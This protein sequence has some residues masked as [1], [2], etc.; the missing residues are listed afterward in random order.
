[1]KR[2][3]GMPLL[4]L[5]EV[6]DQTS[7]L[8][9]AEA[10]E[11]LNRFAAI[12]VRSRHSDGAVIYHG[13]LQALSATAADIPEDLPL[14]RARLR[15]P[16][17]SALPFRLAL[18]RATHSLPLE[19]AADFWQ[20]DLFLSDFTLL[21]DDLVA[22]DLIPATGTMPRHLVPKADNDTPV[23]LT[24]AAGLR[25]ERRGADADVVARLIDPMTNGAPFLPDMPSGAVVHVTCT[26]PHFLIGRSQIGMTLRDMLFDTSETYSP[27]MVTA[28]GQSNAWRGFAMR[29][30]TIYTRGAALGR[31]G[32]SATL[33]DFLIGDPA[34]LQAEIELQFG[35]SP[36]D[37]ATFVFKQG[38]DETPLGFDFDQ[39]TLEITARPGEQVAL[40]ASL[41]MSE[42]PSDAPEG[43][44]G[45]LAE[46]KFPNS[47][48]EI[49]EDATGM[50]AHGDILRIT[51]IE[52]IV[53]DG[54]E[55]QLRK[56]EFTVRM[57]AS[58]TAPRLSVTVA[59]TTL[60]NAVDLTGPVSGLQGMALSA[61]PTPAQSSAAFDWSCPTLGIED[62]G[63]IFELALPEDA[64]GEHILVLT[65]RDTDHAA[66]RLRIKLF[67]D[68]EA[69]V[70]IGCEDGVFDAESPT[71]PR[72]L[73]E[74]LGTYDLTAFHD[75]GGLHAG[76]D[77]AQIIAGGVLVPAGHIAQV[78]L[79]DGGTEVPAVYDR[80]V[81][82]L[83]PFGKDTINAWGEMFPRKDA[84]N[85]YH[86]ALLKWASNYPGAEF[87][88]IGRCD[89]VGSDDFNQ[90]LAEARAERVRAMLTTATG[91]QEA[92]EAG[93]VT[94]LGEQTAGTRPPELSEI[95]THDEE[96]QVGRLIVL[97]GKADDWPKNATGE[98]GVRGDPLDPGREGI[99]T[100]FRRADVFALGGDPLEGAQRSASSITDPDTRRALV[101]SAG[102]AVAPSDNADARADYRVKMVFAWDRPRWSG[103]RDLVPNMAEIEYAWSPSENG[104]STSAEVITVRGKYVYDDL[105]GFT[106]LIL[107]LSSEG[108]DGLLQTE[109]SAL[110]AALSFAP[111]LIPGIDF[112]DNLEG[113][114]A[115]IG[116]LVTI[117]AVGQV[118]L[119]EGSKTTL[120]AVEGKT[121]TRTIADPLAAFKLQL[122]VDYTNEM[123]VSAPILGLRT[124]EAQPMKLRYKKVGLGYDHTAEGAF[125]NRIGVVYANDS[126][127]IEDSGTWQIEGPLGALLR[128]TEFRMGAG[129][130][131]IEPKLALT[132]NAGVVEVSEA[133]FR[134]TFTG[135]EEGGI[136][137]SLRGLSAKVN[138]PATVIGEGRLQIEDGGVIKAAIDVTII[139]MQIRASVALAV[140]SPP[141]IAPSVFVNLY[142]RI[143]FPGGIPLGT[144]PIAIHGFIGQTVINGRRD[145]AE[146]E[147]VVTREIGWW[148]KNPEDKYAPARG[149]YA[150]GLGVVL[151]TLPD[152]SFSLSVTGMVVVAFPDP[153]VILGVEIDLLTIPETTAKDQ[154][155]GNSASI[156]GLVVIDT[157]A[158]TIAASAQYTVPKVLELKLPFGAYFPY[159]GSG[160]SAYVRIG[161]DNVEGRSGQPVTLTILPDT[162]NQKAWCYL[163][164]EG[165]GINR[166]GGEDGWDFDGFAIGLGAGFGVEMK[167]GPI[168]LSASVRLL[169]GVGTTPLIIKGG[170]FVTGK[171][172][173]VVISLG[174][175]GDIVLT[176]IH[177][178]DGPPTLSLEGEFCGEVSM[179]FFSIKGC[180]SFDIGDPPAI[181]PPPPPAPV[182]SISL[183]GR[184]GEVTGEATKG[185]PAGAALYDFIE[186][187]GAVENQG[188]PPEDNHTVWP[189]TVPVLNFAHFIEDRLPS[190]GQ[191]KPEAQPAGA[192][193]FGS[194]R[195]KH[196]Y[197]LTGLRL[198]RE[199]GGGLVTDPE[200]TRLQSAW[201]LSPARAPDDSSGAN[202]TPSEA[203]VTHLQL[204]DWDPFHWARASADG[205]AGQ[206]GDPAEV[207]GR[208]CDP[209][210]D[211]QPFC[212]RGADAR[213]LSP[214][215]Q[216]L[217][218]SA[219]PEG[220]YPSRFAAKGSSVLPR[221][222]GALQGAELASLVNALGLSIRGGAIVT[223]PQINLGGRYV[224]SGLRLPALH[225]V[226]GGRAT[227]TTLPWQ[228]QLDRQ[229]TQGV[230]TLLV[231]DQNTRDPVQPDMPDPR[232]CYHFETARIGQIADHIVL[233]P[234][235]FIATDPAA[236]LQI[237]D[238][239]DLSQPLDPRP[240]QDGRADLQISY[241]GA[242]MVLD[243]PCHDLRLSYL[244]PGTGGLRFV[245]THLDGRESFESADG[246]ASVAITTRL[247][248]Q[249]GIVAV[250]FVLDTKTIQLYQ[251][252][253]A[254]SSKPA[255]RQCVSFTELH[256]GLS[257]AGKISFDGVIA[258][259]LGGAKGLQL[260]DRVDATLT[261]P[262]MRPDGV[263]EIVI[264]PDGL[265]LEFTRLRQCAR[266]E[267][268]LIASGGQ[269]TGTAFGADGQK[270][271]SGTLPATRNVPL[272]LTLVAKH[273]I[274]RVT[275]TGGNGEAALFRI[276]CSTGATAPAQGCIDLARL[277]KSLDGMRSGNHEGLRLSYL[278]GRP[279]ALAD[280]VQMGPVPRAGADGAL[281]LVVPR[282]GVQIALPRPCRH[283]ELHVM[284]FTPRE[285]MAIGYDDAGRVLARARS[286]GRTGQPQIMALRSARG[287]A[288]V[289]ITGG[290]GD[291]VLYRFCCHDGAGQPRITRRCVD[292]KT[293]PQ[294]RRP[295]ASLSRE[296]VEFRD[297]AGD[298]N[299]RIADIVT[300]DDTRIT[301]RRDGANELVFGRGALEILLP[302]PCSYMRLT[303][304]FPGTGRIEAEAFDSNGRRV[305]S[306]GGSAR[307]QTLTLTL[308]GPEMT[309][310][311][312]KNS[313][314]VAALDEIC[315]ELSSAP[316]P[317][318]PNRDRL[319]DAPARENES[320]LPKVT[321]PDTNGE[322]SNWQ[323]NVVQSFARTTSRPACRLV[324]YTMP[325]GL[326]HFERATVIPQSA[327][328]DITLIGLCGVDLK[329]QDWHDQ[330]AKLRDA[331]ILGFSGAPG[332]AVV[333]G[334]RPII[335]D[336]DTTYRIEIDWDYQSWVGQQDTDNA[337]AV[338]PESEWQPGETQIFRFRTASEGTLDEALQ[339]GPNEHIFNPRDLNRYLLEVEPENGAE[340]H[341]TDDP[342]VF[343]FA[344][345]HVPNLL[346]Q[347]QRALDVEIKR[348]DPP[349]MPD[350]SQLDSAR[351]P[352]EGDLNWFD[353]PQDL[354]IPRDQRLAKALAD[355]PCLPED[356][357]PVNGG[358]LAGD[359]PLAPRA[360]YDADL[361]AHRV[362]DGS[363]RV[364]IH[365]SRFMTSRYANP[366]AMIRALG[367][368]TDGTVSAI[369]MAEMVL[370]ADHTVPSDTTPPSDSAFDAALNGMGLGTLGLPDAPRAFQIWQ[371]DA[372]GALRMVAVLIDAVE[373]LRRK[374]SVLQNGKVTRVTRC[375]PLLGRIGQ[376][377]FALARENR[378]STRLLFIAPD[379][380]NA[381]QQD[382]DFELHFDTS[383]G[384]LIGRRYLRA[385]PLVHDI[386]GF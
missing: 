60:G 286:E 322:E 96:M 212:L 246:P 359:F 262:G 293:A 235:A 76:F 226:D 32:F 165:G 33:R 93:R 42:V 163:M 178:P 19:P 201:V 151:G 347:Y 59:G 183:T 95:V 287:I 118:V 358:S 315:Y 145:V 277:P 146:T 160:K 219:G 341:F 70:L 13:K 181:A 136:S 199:Q 258:A 233:P 346:A 196:A 253:C 274:A 144:L 124:A 344:H 238:H 327:D 117:G 175:R 304:A 47:P 348:T 202:G 45:Y 177:P 229:L 23:A 11:F 265:V 218:R 237:L 385:T 211:P 350:N 357:A 49:G 82:L 68:D 308:R 100:L 169:V 342:V 247:T 133:A 81:Q 312:L 249:S 291:T 106:Q 115:R 349:P 126:M 140:G 99:R 69:T 310:I 309:R 185:S 360:M 105:T 368:R 43:L 46:F 208:L 374:A 132:L 325:A 214:T 334:G 351:Q 153:E 250:E 355:A 36:L 171:L 52:V 362:A 317:P 34:G 252:C 379:G 119:Q 89:D 172:D 78:A 254:G 375:R 182:Q 159:P 156:T 48:A 216:R 289:V 39:G 12:S 307:R 331:L 149:Q 193:W 280:R 366:D 263:P 301:L 40:F 103:W 187:N 29:E 381:P 361:I 83:F 221:G 154:K 223:T 217:L 64:Q 380:F 295:V 56:P 299:L 30:A 197:R 41:T 243:T 209:V 231:C 18:R 333:D 236:P 53:T 319:R 284:L 79:D 281:E 206:P 248:S 50:V 88:V 21:F 9:P 373:P 285:V 28:R 17:L 72:A 173:L 142:A 245:I 111:M 372:G 300:V 2:Q 297:P 113:S 352:L 134:L 241:P 91:G 338:P 67:E 174:V 364:T 283:V 86:E 318:T 104:I 128:V 370:G 328:Q 261:P 240:G 259:P 27:P 109:Q 150:L 122:T 363:G 224:D 51:P 323:A 6:T 354:F 102:R 345:N 54:E 164:I 279:L 320:A 71:A 97:R 143:Q 230:L 376:T 8:I 80:Q 228:A 24:G 37:A 26:P 330:D 302:G 340:V 62:D 168:G 251:I 138:I 268:G 378:N 116:A 213:T 139:P 179:F 205:G 170:L 337:P 158:V 92:I 242:R 94:A 84:G 155:E 191:F 189:D 121:E 335:L 152:A 343:H 184:G 275:L 90:N 101:P 377:S 194:S 38:N 215:T 332:N 203:E 256:E 15:L 22:A 282:A 5:F 167:A 220:P 232:D 314:L 131:W 44:T 141:A 225:T 148:R 356:A 305:A 107:G 210:P 73:R 273:P 272:N 123:H 57:V 77:S 326:E 120:V 162:L 4:S 264:P 257:G 166:L 329:V 353:L 16:L 147:D 382:A 290:A 14:G 135:G 311:M 365:S 66:T 61:S 270:I 20:L 195:L 267:I 130:F 296:G 324:R 190:D 269:I 306:E 129:S 386:E 25:L 339:D 271:A 227:A 75:D 367:F 63:A 266:L 207:V 188:V 204:L 336:P 58:G 35:T 87:L 222:A 74:V 200:N 244:R 383:D 186:V 1:M 112:E 288:R 55:R 3:A 110:V 278:N 276:C 369:T 313:A 180:V 316:T 255:P 292:F 176:C 108:G 31:G 161:A 192:R 125:I 294:T 239:V 303:L 298:A 98:W 137:F 114:L 198:L 65:Q 127:Q 157:Q 7:G 384:L 260:V 85:T 10:V 371:A 234:Y 321:S